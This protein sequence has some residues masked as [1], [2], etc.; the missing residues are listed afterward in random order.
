MHRIKYANLVI[1]A[2]VIEKTKVHEQYK[3]KSLNQFCLFTVVLAFVWDV[4][5]IAAQWYPA[6]L[7]DIFVQF[8]FGLVIVLNYK[9]HYTIAKVV[10]ILSTNL[11]VLGITFIL[12]Y[13]SGFYLYLFTAPFF[14]FWL[15]DLKKEKLSIIISTFTYFIC[16]ITTLF[17][18][19]NVDPIVLIT[20]DYFQFTIYDLNIIFALLFSIFLFHNYTTYF[21]ILRN[22]LILEQ[23]KLKG[24]IIL[25]RKDQRKL[26]RIYDRVKIANVNLEQ[27]GF[28]VSHNIRAPFANIKGFLN[29]YEPNTT[30]QNENNEVVECIQKSVINLD[31]VLNDLAFLLTLK[32]DLQEEK[33]ELLLSTLI[34]SVKQSLAFE[35]NKLDIT[36]HEVYEPSFQINTVSSIFHSIIFNLVQNAIKYR[37]QTIQTKITLSATENRKESII[38]LSDNG[39]GIDLDKHHAKLFG[40]YQRFHSHIEGKG[41]GLYMIKKQVHLLGGD[42]KVD[43]TPNVGTCFII[44]LP[45]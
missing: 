34:D 44:T 8:S 18:K 26:K 29:L 36:L 35:L 25:R 20:T 43:S 1:N 38:T 3:L 45:K 11:S 22:Q 13:H 14:V 15:F 6:A 2:G 16:Y 4:F 41:V 19:N 32:N 39:I 33:E 10:L 9:K 23:E 42:I 37:N 7:F 30:D 5:F 27:F 12:G 24:E 28:I 40:L 17:F 21:L 31:E